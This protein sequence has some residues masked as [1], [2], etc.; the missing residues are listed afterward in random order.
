MVGEC[1]KIAQYNLF[2][3]KFLIANVMLLLPQNRLEIELSDPLPH[4]WG[5]DV[6]LVNCDPR[7]EVE[8]TSQTLE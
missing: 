4:F 1:F 3:V 5:C 8:V 7:R 6:N 2:T